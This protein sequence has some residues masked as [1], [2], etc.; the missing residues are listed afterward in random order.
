VSDIIMKFLREQDMV[1]LIR[2]RQ[3]LHSAAGVSIYCLDVL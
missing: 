1:K 2:V 3:Y